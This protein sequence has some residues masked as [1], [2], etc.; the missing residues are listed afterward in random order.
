MGGGSKG[1]SRGVE[2]AGVICSGTGAWSGV[3][4]GGGEDDGSP[5]QG[6]KKAHSGGWAAG[7]SVA[8]ERRGFPGL[9]LAMG[10]GGDAAGDF[11]GAPGP[12]GGC[13]LVVGVGDERGGRG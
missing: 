12:E 10:K 1:G 9:L 5:G 4:A 8:G 6:A 11:W 2:A 13:L 3:R 7:G